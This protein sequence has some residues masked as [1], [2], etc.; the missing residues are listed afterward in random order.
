MSSRQEL[1]ETVWRSLP[2]LRKRLVGR[3]RIDRITDIAIDRAPLEV[4]PY[5]GSG[6]QE[7]EIVCRAWQIAVK[8]KYCK[9]HGE[10]AI[11][12]G[13]MF[14]IIVAPLIQYAIK[15]ILE[16]WLESRANQVLLAGWRKE[17]IPS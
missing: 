15:V 7:E 17:G 3:E 13:P 4:M 1:R 6:S 12:F 11:Q 14:W 9:T 10:D 5:V 2:C 16:W 8:T